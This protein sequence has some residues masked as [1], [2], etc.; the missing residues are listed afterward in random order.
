M[1]GDREPLVAC[2]TVERIA[3]QLA[4]IASSVRVAPFVARLIA[5]AADEN[6]HP[7]EPNEWR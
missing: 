5:E 4:A 6:P 1:P 3:A 7:T 2:A